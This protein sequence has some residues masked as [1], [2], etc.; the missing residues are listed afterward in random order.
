MR[1]TAN[2]IINPWGRKPDEIYETHNRRPP[3]LRFTFSWLVRRVKDSGMLVCTL[4]IF[5]TSHFIV[6]GAAVRGPLA[7]MRG[8]MRTCE[9][10]DAVLEKVPNA[11]VLGEDDGMDGRYDKLVDKARAGTVWVRTPVIVAYGE[12]AELR[13]RLFRELDPDPPHGP[14]GAVLFDEDFVANLGLFAVRGGADGAHFEAGDG[15]VLVA[16]LSESYA[17]DLVRNALD[18]LEGCR[19]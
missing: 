13:A 18:S 1:K 4:W 7:K 5:G 9:F 15:R 6:R 8:R 10:I 19:A 14:R 11:R 16:A 12:R 3:D 2:R 17:E